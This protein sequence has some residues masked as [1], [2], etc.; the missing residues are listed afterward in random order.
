MPNLTKPS[1]ANRVV[2]LYR[3][4]EAAVLAYPGADMFDE[5]LSMIAY[6]LWKDENR[7]TAHTVVGRAGYERL[8]RCVEDDWPGV[9]SRT[10]TMLSDAEVRLCLR[11]IQESGLGRERTEFSDR[12]LERMVC[13]ADRSTRG[14]FFTPRHVADF[15]LRMLS[16]EP[17]DIVLDP[18]CGSGILLL[19][20]LR[21]SPSLD[22]CCCC[23]IDYDDRAVRVAR[24][25]MY[26]EGRRHC[27][28]R[29]LDSLKV[30][31]RRL[32]EKDTVEG[33]LKSWYGAPV[34]D[35]IVTN[36][37]FSG[38]VDSKSLPEE[39]VLSKHRGRVLRE[40]LFL[41]RCERLLR[42]GGKLAIILPD[43]VLVST[44]DAYV[45]QWLNSRFR[46]YAVVSLPNTTFEPYTEIQTDIIFARKRMSPLSP[47]C[48]TGPSEKIM[49]GVCE[50]VGKDRRG[51]L[52][53]RKNKRRCADAVRHDLDDILDSF[54]SFTE[55][56]RLRW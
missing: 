48:D 31:D 34:V 50:Q 45:R 53:Y 49:L 9:L 6:K 43:R 22:E 28:F 16:P 7:Q 55:Q 5:L 23:G 21:H 4:I 3:H 15:I 38:F 35:V 25:L 10:S 17:D 52:L 33:A 46:I 30:M 40:I 14:Q 26:T 2:T 18:A 19:A 20:A 12:L 13:G 32:S 41:E 51:N 8:L 1:G 11:L 37:P 36:P 44:R 56:E 39:Y 42:P 29:T 24:L 54:R 27:R 47:G